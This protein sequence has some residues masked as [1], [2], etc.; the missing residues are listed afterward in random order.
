MSET[1]TTDH[2]ALENLAV[3]T[4]RVLSF[5]CV[6]RANSG[7]PGLPMGCADLAYTLFTNS[8]KF[9]PKDPGWPDRDRFV[10]SAGHGS[11]LMYSMLHLCGYDVPLEELKNF[12]QWG[13][14]TPG[15]PEYGDTPGVETT[16]GPLGQGTANAVGL[17]LAESLLAA[18]FNTAEHTL[19]DHFTYALVSD[20]DLMEGISH[21]AASLAGH[22]GLGK[23][24]YLFDSNAITI[25]GAT[26]LASSENTAGRFE[27]YGWHVQEI[28]GH[29]RQAIAG[30]LEAARGET[31]R[32][33]I[34]IATTTIGFGSPNKAG[35]SGVHG[36]PLGDEECG[37]T[38]EALGWDY[39]ECTVPDEVRPLFLEPG[40]RG[41]EKHSAWNEM[42]ESYREKNPELAAEWDRMQA[43]EMPA[44]LREKLPVFESSE[45]SLA[46]RSASGK[47][48]NAI[49]ETIPELIGGSADLA[50]SNNTMVSGQDSIQGS[51]MDGRNMHFGI[52]EHAMGAM[53]NGMA[54]HGGIRPYGGTFLV[55]S[56]YM[57]PSVRLAA[58][59]KQPVVYIWTHDSI[60]LGEDGPTHQ[61]VEHLAALR[62]IP[63][64]RVFRPA[65]ANETAMA[66]ALSLEHRKGPSAILL[67]RQGLP[68]Y[69]ETV[70]GKGSEKG[71]YVIERE[72]GDSGP[73]VILLASGSEVA[74]AR[75][76]AA[77][78]KAQGTGVRVVSMP[79]WEVFEE[80]DAD[81]RESVLPR[82]V[83]ARVAVEAAC[84][85][86]WDRYV[87]ADGAVVCLDRFG[88][89]AP[90]KD[91]AENFG[92]TAENVAAKASALLEG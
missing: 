85:F 16:T 9:D 55:F 81:Y 20:G 71:G 6:Q 17:A 54:L 65:D 36:S 84:S 82:S 26:D 48:I 29:D 1:D 12:R 32:P 10:L 22:L 37:L 79:C 75:E 7:H 77:L 42:L 90:I 51:K 74:T 57:R 53:M 27:N 5:E 72:E 8:L 28:D 14:M 18:R 38:R 45:G 15:H 19:V 40:H 62:A 68:I 35:T 78:L 87:G 89:S 56:D 80:Q 76:A 31:A 3:N 91:L 73:A 2:S 30:A 47:V 46:T 34:I 4:I 39:P 66:W 58:L 59:M 52:R 70:V 88:A 49:A 86:G 43:G 50:P 13:S 21:E 61:P 60:F 33:S 67:S 23:L 24:V 63:N 92:F 11:M 44:G 25:E 41:A 83:T 69:D 64:L